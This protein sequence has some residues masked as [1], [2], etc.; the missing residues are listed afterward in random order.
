MINRT[1]VSGWLV[2]IA[3]FTVYF[4][5]LER[6]GSLWDCGEFVLGA[7]KLQVVHPPGAPLFLIIG[8]IFTWFAELLSDNPAYIAFSVNIMSAICSALAA[9]FICWTTIYFTRLALN[10]RNYEAASNNSLA[11]MGAGVV[12]GLSAAFI[13]TTWFSAVEGEVYSM[14]TMFTTMTFWALAKWYYIEDN[15]K[16]DKWLIFGLYATGLSVGVHLLSLLTFP[17]FALLYY[18]KRYK[19]HTFSGM[20][21]AS[22]IG[23]LFIFLFQSVIV[24]GIPNLWSKLELLCVNSFGLPFHS[25]LAPTLLILVAAIYYG[26]KFTQRRGYDL[27]H[28]FV[29]AFML[30]VI[31]SSTVGVVLIRANAKPP[32]NMNDPYDVMRLVPYLNRE[33]YGDRDLLKG[34]HFDAI[35][36][37]MKQEDRWGRKKNKYAVVDRK[38]SYVYSKKDEIFFPRISHNDQGRSQLH[39]MWM[40]YITGKKDGKPTTAYNFGFLWHYQLGWMYWRY[41]MWNFVG[42]QNGEQGFFPWNKKDGHWLSGIKA[43]DSKRLYNQDHLPR[44][45]REDEARNRYYFIPLFLGI[46]GL[47]YHF[48]KNKNDFLVLLGLFILTGLG[49]CIYNNSPPNE[50]RERDYVLVGSF[51]T[52]CIWIGMAVLFLVDFIEN[53]LKMSGTVPQYLASCLG[54]IVPAILVFVN[55]DDHS[56]MHSTG[57]RDY[58]SNIL[59]SCLP[60]AILFTY[61][62]NDTYPV[63][64]AQEVEGIR[65]DVRVINLSLIAVDWY[66]ENQRRKINES[67]PVKLQIPTEQYRGYLRNQVYYYNPAGEGADRVMDARDFLKY[68]GEDHPIATGSGREIETH[69]PTR[70]IFIPVDPKKAVELG[71]IQPGDTAVS[72]GIPVNLNDKQ[73]L[74]KDELAVLDIITNNINDRPIYFS[75]TCQDEKLMG[76]QDYTNLEGM[77]LRIVPV[78]SPSDKSF[79]IYGSGRCD[80]DKT[81][82]IVMNKFRWGNFDKVDQFVDHSYA[83]S[84]QAMRFIMLRTALTL[85]A[86]GDT[87][88]AVNLANKYF[89]SF[90]NMNFQ[91]DLRVMPFIEILVNARETEQAKKHLTIL[92]TETADMMEFYNSLT[93]DELDAGFTQDK[94]MASSAIREILTQSQALGDQ[95]FIAQIEQLLGKYKQSPGN[96]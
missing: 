72:L 53:R 45:I 85:E 87:T 31:A 54:L 55:F 80:Y 52:F 29:F 1:N 12:A 67:P 94:S 41:F 78:K 19:K 48:R 93:P 23:V 76:M 60:N 36:I 22:L 3:A 38:L 81:Y 33:Q 90:P 43:I 21:I 9:M 86:I 96:I 65:R 7:Y 27:A 56:R 61:G 5:S 71:M 82:D 59:E 75:V 83:P 37:N 16:N 42:R 73:Y 63:W 84:I 13:S 15:P 25:G 8:R 28:K 70:S 57:A 74:I 49:L 2:F 17:V 95:E 92:A 4:F 64:Y 50:P 32:I 11:I 18:F 24:T 66:I 47:T 14:S 34:P 77:A 6:T 40:N 39:R 46:L 44:A 51:I 88:R 26:L 89:E 68:V 10:G 91:Y 58:A 20:A 69:M 79:Y 30:L 35:P 62:D